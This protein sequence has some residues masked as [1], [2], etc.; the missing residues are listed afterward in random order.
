MKLY[1]IHY[2]YYL[3]GQLYEQHG[4]VHVAAHALADARNLGKLAAGRL[5]G[6]KVHV[7]GVEEVRVPGLVI[8]LAPGEPEAPQERAG[9]SAP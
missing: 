8:T 1:I 3:E 2:G 6:R 9:W 7:D 5:T 4:C